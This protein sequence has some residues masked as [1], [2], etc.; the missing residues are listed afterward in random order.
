MARLHIYPHTEP[1]EDAVIVADPVALRALANAMLKAA[2]TIHGFQRV[3]LHTSDGHEY[4]AM[5]VSGLQESEWQTVAPAYRGADLP[6]LS[7]LEDY[8]SM[9]KELPETRSNVDS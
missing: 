7:V 2:Q 6:T 8:E 1:Q 9:K 5:I 3:K 4:Y